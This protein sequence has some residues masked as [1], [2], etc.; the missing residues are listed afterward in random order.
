MDD[1][2]IHLIV[3][4]AAGLAGL[5]FG[6]FAER[7][8]YCLR[9]GIVDALYGGA[10]PRLR[11]WLLSVVVAMVGTQG[12]VLAGVVDLS[13]TIYVSGAFQFGGVLL[14]GLMFGAGMVLSGGCISRLLVLSG[15]GNLRA[16]TVL[17]FTGII[18]YAALR[19]LFA[20]PRIAWQDATAFNIA[21]HSLSG[22]LSRAT[23]FPFCWPV[24][25]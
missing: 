5:V 17:A 3:A 18:A 24:S 12:L 2:E 9:G 19:G 8:G 13:G 1:I 4:T 14:G 23:G 6:F 20:L 11:A 22:L 15:T 16:I 25:L 21:D 7:T 10:A